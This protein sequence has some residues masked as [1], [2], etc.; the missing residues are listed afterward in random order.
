MEPH[1]LQADD[2]IFHHLPRAALQSQRRLCFPSNMSTMPSPLSLRT[3]YTQVLK[4]LPQIFTF[5]F[6][7]F[8]VQVSPY[9]RSPPDH[10]PTVYI[11]PRNFTTQQSVP[12]GKLQS[13]Y[14]SI[15]YFPLLESRL[16]ATLHYS[17]CCYQSREQ[18]LV[19][20]KNLI[21]WVMFLHVRS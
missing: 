11:I 8:S 20:S 13:T 10:T 7:P 9:Q 15:Y 12:L 16:H 5:P 17:L 21:C 3:C 14:F 1:A 19:Q 6:L 18:C 4:S 2:R